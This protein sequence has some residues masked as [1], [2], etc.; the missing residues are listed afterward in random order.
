[1]PVGDPTPTLRCE[2]DARGAG[3]T[4]EAA[5]GYFFDAGCFARYTA[6]ELQALFDDAPAADADIAVLEAYAPLVALRME[7]ERCADQ[8][9]SFLVD[10]PA[11][12]A[13]LR[14]L[15]GPGTSKP[16]HAQLQAIAVELFYELSHLRS[17]ITSVEVVPGERNPRADAVS[18]GHWQRLAELIAPSQLPRYLMQ[19]TA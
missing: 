9:L 19:R 4:E 5:I 7:P 18:R 3:T 8:L 10:N 1:M 11:A 13:V 12:G 6:S 2:T 16:L 15:R 17:R 14:K